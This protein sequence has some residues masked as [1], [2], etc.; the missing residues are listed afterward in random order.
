[1]NSKKTKTKLEKQTDF[2]ESAFSYDFPWKVE[3]GFAIAFSA[4]DI[5][6]GI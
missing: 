2:S 5:V 3:I 1:M 6:E 4:L